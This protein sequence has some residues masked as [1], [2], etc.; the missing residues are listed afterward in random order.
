MSFISLLRWL[1]PFNKDTG[2]IDKQYQTR[3]Q[4]V[5]SHIEKQSVNLNEQREKEIGRLDKICPICGAAPIAI[6]PDN[7]GVCP[8]CGMS[9][10]VEAWER[11]NAKLEPPADWPYIEPL[12][13]T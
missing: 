13:Y 10:G 4:S 3:M 7:I 1:L 9:M 5:V 11:T 8:Q 2:G 6:V 12:N